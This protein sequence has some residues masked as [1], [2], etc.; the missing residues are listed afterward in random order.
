MVIDELRLQYTLK[1][2]L[3]A[4]GLKKSTYDYYRT[5][6]HREAANRR[7]K[8]EKRILSI[9]KPVF[10]HHRARYGSRRILLACTELNGI[11]HKKLRRLCPVMV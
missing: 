10:D 1:N 9:I 7:A 3:R 2:L 6:K 5:P 8:E 4:S 11:N